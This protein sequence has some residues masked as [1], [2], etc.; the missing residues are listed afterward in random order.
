MGLQDILKMHTEEQ[1]KEM[2]KMQGK[3]TNTITLK[4]S[5][6]HQGMGEAA[7]V[8]N[9]KTAVL[10]GFSSITVKNAQNPSSFHKSSTSRPKDNT[11]IANFT[12]KLYDMQ[13]NHVHL[14]E[15]AGN[16]SSEDEEARK[17]EV[18]INLPKAN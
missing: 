2:H 10:H 1:M 17:E 5:T 12:M 3:L 9:S 4:R 7:S 16:L 13:K 11:K 6:Q 8:S 18:K 15:V 14:D